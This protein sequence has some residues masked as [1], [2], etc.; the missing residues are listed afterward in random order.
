MQSAMLMFVA[1]FA[2]EG[3]R[4]S[5]SHL[6]G[7]NRLATGNV[8]DAGILVETAWNISVTSES[9]GSFDCVVRKIRELFR[10]G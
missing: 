5:S 8:V 2:S 9:S 7:S 4:E 10:S 3:P 6:R 1:R